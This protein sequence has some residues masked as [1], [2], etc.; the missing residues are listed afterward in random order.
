MIDE[1]REIERARDRDR[2]TQRETPGEKGWEEYTWEHVVPSSLHFT[3]VLG[4]WKEAYC[5]P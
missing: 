4:V 2:E 5:N 1:E 3:T